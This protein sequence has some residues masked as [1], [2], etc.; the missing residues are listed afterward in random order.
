MFPPDLNLFERDLEGGFLPSLLDISGGRDLTY[1]CLSFPSSSTPPLC[2]DSTV[3]FLFHIWTGSVLVM[4]S[5]TGFVKLR[6]DLRPALRGNEAIKQ[7]QLS[8]FFWSW[9]TFLIHVCLVYPHSYQDN[10]VLSETLYKGFTI[11]VH[12]IIHLFMCC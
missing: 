1:V 10:E 9:V 6:R 2:L 11:T 3:T 4:P 12:R 8:R 7:T 5:F